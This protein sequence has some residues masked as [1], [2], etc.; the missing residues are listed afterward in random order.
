MIDAYLL[1]KAVY[2]LGYELNNRPDWLRI[3]ILG[4]FDLLG[5][6]HS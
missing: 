2:E 5:V 6:K 1:D 4:I 3:P